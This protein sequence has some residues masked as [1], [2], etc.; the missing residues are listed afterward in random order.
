MSFLERRE[1]ERSLRL[2]TPQ[3]TL[4]ATLPQGLG[5]EET[6]G[7]V[8]EWNL[9]RLPVTFRITQAH[10]LQHV[11]Q[12]LGTPVAWEARPFLQGT[13]VYFDGI[14]AQL[15]DEERTELCAC[16]DEVGACY[17]ERLMDSITRLGLWAYPPIDSEGVI[18]VRLV[19]VP[20]WLWEALWEFSQA[21]DFENGQT[22]WHCFIPQNDSLR[23]EGPQLV[24]H[25]SLWPLY[26]SRRHR[27]R[28][29]STVDVVYRFPNFPALAQLSSTPWR[30]LVAEGLIWTAPATEAWLRQALIPHVLEAG[31]VDT[32][33][34]QEVEQVLARQSRL[35]SLDD[36]PLSV[37]HFVPY[38]SDIRDWLIATQYQ[39]PFSGA[40]PGTEVRAFL[41]ACIHL[42][43]AIELSREHLASVNAALGCRARHMKDLRLILLGR[44]EPLEGAE[45]LDAHA[46]DRLAE[47]LEILLRWGRYE[48]AYAA[49]QQTA[50]QLGPLWRYARF[51]STFR[52]LLAQ[53]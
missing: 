41:L 32:A 22:P 18:G 11:L 26:P 36:E 1:T 48:G 53:Q 42:A 14:T 37:R 23:I 47:G 16:L 9:A 50:T 45:R 27:H 33:R 3:I 49:L 51:H 13:S 5:A 29:P 17:Q 10:L 2:R 52:G 40:V 21:H 24:P 30:D 20:I 6:T 8:V 4:D 28:A 31:R 44:Q 34:V 15:T 25:A 7:A 39:L 12:G 35:P 38:L 46:T 19:S 43:N